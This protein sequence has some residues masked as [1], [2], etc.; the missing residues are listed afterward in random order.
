MNTEQNIYPEACTYELELPG[1]KLKY[2]GHHMNLNIAERLYGHRSNARNNGHC[3]SKYLFH[4]ANDYKDVQIRILR[5]FTNITKGELKDEERADIIAGGYYENKLY[6]DRLPSSLPTKELN[7]QRNAKKREDPEFVKQEND[8]K[9]VFRKTDKGKAEHERK[10][11]ARRIKAFQVIPDDDMSWFVA[12]CNNATTLFPLTKEEK[13]NNRRRYVKKWSMQ[14][15]GQPLQRIHRL[16][17]PNVDLTWFNHL[18]FYAHQ[19]YPL[20]AEENANRKRRIKV[21]WTLAKKYGPEH[22]KN[23]SPNRK[24][25]YDLHKK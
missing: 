15:T 11:D 16:K 14:K 17:D 3:N 7:K 6:N 5:T 25:L 13:A 22:W 19:I 9:K 4:T 1:H 18:A 23:I 12:I 20:S 10:N 2:R 21:N 24:R 8:K